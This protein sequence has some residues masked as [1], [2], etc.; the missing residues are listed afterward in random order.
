MELYSIIST[1]ITLFLGGGWF[2]HYRE[3]KI[4]AKGEA[5]QAEAEGWLKQQEAYH[6]TIDELTSHC[7]FIKQDRNLLREENVKLR[8]ENNAL[9]EKINTL[10]EQIF[11]MKK[12]ISRLGRRVEGLS[13][14][15]KIK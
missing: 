13:K 15:N 5:S 8:K 2:I 11:D 6:N 7:E 3:N 1:I 4:K 14:F 9:R 10:E 12:E